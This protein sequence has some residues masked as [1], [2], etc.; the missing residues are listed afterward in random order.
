MNLNLTTYP[1]VDVSPLSTP[2][3]TTSSDE[4]SF[5]SNPV[6][7]EQTP[8]NDNFPL[9]PQQTDTSSSIDISSYYFYV[10]E[11]RQTNYDVPKTPSYGYEY[12]PS[13]QEAPVVDNDMYVDIDV[14]V[15][16]PGNNT[17]LTKRIKFCKQSLA[18]EALAK[19]A[20]LNSVATCVEN[21]QAPQVKSSTQRMLELAG[22]NHPKNYV[23]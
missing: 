4:V 16:A 23:L 22:I 13:Q 21:K 11:A 7:G 6:D 17:R 10:G 20:M 9:G 1:Y 12:D 8:P 3:T 14:M 2:S 5:T 19:N 15:N 18:Q